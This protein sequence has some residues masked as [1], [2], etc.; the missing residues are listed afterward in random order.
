[1]WFDFKIQP[2]QPIKVRYVTKCWL[3]IAK[4]MHL[5]IVFSE[6][7]GFVCSNVIYILRLD[8]T[9][10]GP[11]RKAPYFKQYIIWYW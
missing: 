6:D 9:T 8:N 3:D 5:T 11:F 1:M 4:L 10:Q 7:I 2:Y